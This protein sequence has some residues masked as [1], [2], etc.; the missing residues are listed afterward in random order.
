MILIII[1]TFKLYPNDITS[2]DKRLFLKAL[3]IKR[4]QVEYF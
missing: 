2:F 3:T 4:V 1:I